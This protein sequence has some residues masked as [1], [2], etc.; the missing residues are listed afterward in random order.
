MTEGTNHNSISITTGTM[1]RV[2]LVVLGAY[3]SWI[4]RDFL[5]IL[6]T[7]IIIASFMESVVP[8]FKKIRIG[9]VAG[10]VILYII[11]ISM[12][13][14]IFYMFAPLLLTEIYNFSN[15]LAPYVPDN[16]FLRYF[17]SDEFSGAKDLVDSLPRDF[18][19]ASLFGVSQAF[20]NNLSGGFVK[21]ISA[22][23]GSIFNAV[24][25][26]IISFYLSIQ[27]KG[28]E[29]FLRI[30]LP[31]KYEDYAVDLWH[32]SRR[33]IALWMKGQ[34]FL[35]L[36]ITVLTFLVLSLLGFKY[37][38]LL[39][40]IAGLMEFV[41]YGLIIAL[42]P[43]VGFSYISGGV[44]EAALVA[45]AYIIIHQFE[46]FLFQPLIINKVV[47]LSPLV[48]IIAVL[49]GFEL[50]GVWGILLSIPV[51]VVIMEFMNDV[52]KKKI[53]VRKD[54]GDK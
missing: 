19:V 46:I 17:Q 40:I 29:N 32:R 10:M 4:L 15:V 51:A 9:R 25:I 12:L 41:P 52:E 18:S 6:I 34:I 13:F 21:T 54:N 36:I 5:L 22:A 30:I 24:V 11:V 45:G 2:V 42:V 44:S 53:L 37:A 7:S 50:G 14:G 26:V 3:L 8:L 38:L 49:L 31:L 33:K 43:A 16:E 47:G 1:V 39:A 27:E 23:F 20:I 35:A 28:I 48:V